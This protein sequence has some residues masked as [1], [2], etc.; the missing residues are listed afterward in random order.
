MLR[1]GSLSSNLLRLLL[2]FLFLGLFGAC[3]PKSDN[4][5]AET[6]R[7]GKCVAFYPPQNETVHAY[8]KK[9]CQSG[10]ERIYDYLLKEKGDVFELSYRDGNIFYTERDMSELQLHIIDG[11]EMLSDM[12]RYQMRK[13]QY[14]IAYTA[15]FWLDTYPEAIDLSMIGVSIAEDRLKLHFDEYDYDLYLPLGYA[16]FLT[17]K[18]LGSIDRSSYDKKIYIDPNRPMVALTYDDG[19]YD[20]VDR[21]LYE[22]FQRYGVKATFYSVGSRMSEEELANM[23]AGI[24]A[25][26]EFG[27]HT[28]YHKN[29]FKQDVEEARWAIMEPVEY[30]DEMLGYRMK[31]Y[32]P[33]YG[34]RNYDLEDSIGMPA[35]LWTVDS[36]DWSNR[37][38]DVT[39]SNVMRDIRDGDIVLMHSL[40]MSSEKASE[41]LV[42]DLMNM[43]FQL[44]TVSELLEYKGIDINTLRVYGHN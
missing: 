7:N 39:Y 11:E 40:Y 41:R 27:S 16:K 36:K 15:S 8:A 21:K 30:V 33:P 20:A 2:V 12:L 35:I 26:M 22:L 43:G 24:K 29:L 37:D 10:E 32:R 31:T 14:D 38:A 1:E 4:E 6:Y 9:L 42:P 19:P 5:G 28:E 25:G 34:S 23:K 18:N 44:V 3:A 17:G 13:D